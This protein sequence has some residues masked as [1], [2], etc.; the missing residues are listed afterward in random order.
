MW[1]VV[2]VGLCDLF[3]C[4]QLVGSALGSRLP[5]G[6]WLF[7]LLFGQDPA[8][9]GLT[10]TGGREQVQTQS[11]ANTI[12]TNPQRNMPFRVCNKT[13]LTWVELG[14][15]SSLVSA[16]CVCFCASLCVVS[17]YMKYSKLTCYWSSVC[18]WGDRLC[19]CASS[20]HSWSSLPDPG[21][22]H[23]VG[24]RGH[25]GHRTG[26]DTRLGRGRGQRC[27]SNRHSTQTMN[28]GV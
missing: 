13:V 5:L 22:S 1:W 27:Q 26:S 18:L 14:A 23:R 28:I 2:K 17:G 20:Y 9:L 12:R 15:Y 7:G 21:C 4:L 11:Q 3:C 6:I 16:L 19:V 24:P 10:G 25:R 8:S